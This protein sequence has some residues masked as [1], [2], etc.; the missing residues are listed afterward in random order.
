MASLAL[1]SAVSFAQAQQSAP[2][3]DDAVKIGLDLPV[4]DFF[5]H[6]G[7]IRE[8]GRMVRDMYIVKVK[9]SGAS[10]RPRDVYDVIAMLPGNVAFQLLA[11]S[12]CPLV[13]Q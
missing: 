7:R 6:G 8:D 4:E 1:V 13:K 9:A 10:H 2:S 11:D 12:T 3:P 5:A